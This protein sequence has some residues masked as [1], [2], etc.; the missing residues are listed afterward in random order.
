MQV[1]PRANGPVVA[2]ADVLLRCDAGVMSAHTGSTLLT[3]RW[4]SRPWIGDTRVQALVAITAGAALLRFPTLREQS[5][6]YDEAITV[7]LVRRPFDAMLGAVPQ[8]ESTPPLYYVL[9]WIWSHIFGTG[10]ASLRSL[11]AVIGTATVP[12]T[13]AA[14]REFVSTRS[15]FVAAALVAVSPLLVWYSQEAR[16]Y[17]L[18]V[19]L[20]ALSLV[21][22]RRAAA[23]RPAGALAA[24]ALTASAALATHYFAIFLIAAEALWLVYR[25]S[26]RRA[27]AKAIAAVAAVAVALAGLAA[28]Q[29]RHAEHTA[30]ISNSGGVAGRAAHLLRQLVVGTY[31]VEDIRPLLVAVPV[32]VVVGLFAW[33]DRAERSGALL[34][35]A[36]GVAAI[37]LPAV[38]AVL[39]NSFFGGRGDYFIYRNVIV[40]T[41]PLTIAAAAVFATPRAGR[42]GAAAVAVTCASLAFV[43]VEI[44]RRP[45]LQKP[46]VR[47]VAEV[48]ATTS[49]PRAIV[50]DVRTAAVLNVY[51]PD[52]IDAPEAGVPI[53]EVD[54]IGE[55]GSAV[56]PVPPPGFHRVSTRAVD[57]FTVVRLRAPRSRRV[58]PATLKL[59]LRGGTEFAVLLA[60]VLR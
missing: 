5:Y 28:Y 20:G 31:P 17:A 56:S 43:S 2:V 30:W 13:Y 1:N 54:V 52:A 11:S 15:A 42:L 6:W 59:Q 53:Q 19:L 12:A 44:A 32:V 16:A 49:T 55:P 48:S 14:G 8:S 24:W 3:R 51:L 25:A 23:S 36:F 18:L 9:A 27:A 50:A 33:T 47:A 35:L 37:A 45:D 40:A 7:D 38:L 34:A 60:R 26:H 10:E 29:A 4:A 57:E 22:L 41:V 21:P 58:L 46:D 39:G